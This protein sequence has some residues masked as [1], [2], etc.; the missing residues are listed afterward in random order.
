MTTIKRCC[1]VEECDIF[2][3]MADYIGLSVLHP[4][5]FTATDMLLGQFNI[6]KDSSVLDIACGKGTTA[7]YIAQKYGCK[8]VGID[9]SEELIGY[10]KELVKKN[11]LEENVTLELGDALDLPYDNNEFDYAVSQAMLILVKDKVKAIQEA[12][13]V[14]RSGAKAGWIELSWKKNPTKEFMDEVSNVICAF[15]M[16]NVETF[17]NWEKL[18]KK[19]NSS[20]FMAMKSSM[21]F[22][23]MKGMIDDEGFLNSLKIMS[24]FLFSQKVRKR[25]NALNDFF[26]RYPEY[27]GYGIYILTK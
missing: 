16:E 11:G 3:F 27:F 1:E 19:T 12:V 4:G 9:I 23:G 5:G 13:R 21:E 6:N 18:F 22:H 24:K 26:S 10:G 17:E 25:M 8:V 15:C 20:N 2:D 14:I 7:V